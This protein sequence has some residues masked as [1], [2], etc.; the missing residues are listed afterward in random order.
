M[1]DAGGNVVTDRDRGWTPAYLGQR[2]NAAIKAA[3]VDC[4][5]HKPGTATAP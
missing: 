4:T 2:V 5:F 1:P 3:G